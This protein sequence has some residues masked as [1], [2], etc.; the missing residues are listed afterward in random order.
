MSVLCISILQG[1][2]RA[3]RASYVRAGAASS[4]ERANAIGRAAD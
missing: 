3:L 4:G 2:W 1:R